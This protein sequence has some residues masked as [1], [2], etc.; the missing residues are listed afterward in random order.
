MPP[1]CTTVAAASAVQLL[2][3]WITKDAVAIQS[4]SDW[5]VARGKNAALFVAK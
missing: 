3:E 1:I 5:Q 2:T 4:F